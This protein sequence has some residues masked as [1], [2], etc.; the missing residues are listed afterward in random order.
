M[1]SQVLI[2]LSNIQLSIV[3]GGLIQQKFDKTVQTA[4]KYVKLT[5]ERKE[6]LDLG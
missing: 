1:E 2:F 6:I 4:W 3:N 5:L